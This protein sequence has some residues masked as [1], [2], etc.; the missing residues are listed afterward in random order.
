M[1]VLAIVWMALLSALSPPRLSRWRVVWP[2]EA[3]IGLVPAS[4]AKAASL[5][6]RPGWENETMAWAALTGPIPGRVVSP[7]TRSLTIAASSV[8]L[9]LSARAA[10][11]SARASRR[12]SPWR[13]ACSRLA[14][15]GWRRRARAARTASLSGRGPG[16]GRC[17]LR[18]VTARAVG[19][20][21]RYCW[22]SA[23]GA[24]T[25]GCAGLRGR[26]RRGGWAGDRR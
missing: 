8:R 24:R 2:L 13:M 17:R 14:P 22:W 11:R 3:S 12:I 1:R 25:A 26:R 20:F 16:G 21:A 9:A 5:R 23:L 10:R 6:Q 7:G 4:L 15:A 19:W 18:R